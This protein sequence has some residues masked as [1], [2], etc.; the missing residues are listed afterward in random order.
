MVGLMR[1]GNDRR[2]TAHH[3]NGQDPFPPS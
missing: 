1:R 2:K 3:R